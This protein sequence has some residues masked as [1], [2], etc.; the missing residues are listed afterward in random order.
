MEIAAVHLSSAVAAL[1]AVIGVV[2]TED[3]L[4]RVFGDFCIGK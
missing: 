3:L 2:D 1:E 4:G